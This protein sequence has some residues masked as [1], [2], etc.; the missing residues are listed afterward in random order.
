MAQTDYLRAGRVLKPQGLRGEVKVEILG[1]EPEQILTQKSFYLE[2]ARSGRP[3]AASRRQT[4]GGTEYVP[5]TVLAAALRE[6]YAYLE[7]AG[8][9]SREEAEALRGAYLCIRREDALPLPEG[10]WYIVDL[11]GCRAFGDDGRDYGTL[12]DIHQF[13]AA[14]IY[15]LRPDEGTE[16][17]WTPLAEGL[18]LDVNLQEKKLLLNGE[19]VRQCGVWNPR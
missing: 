7:L 18:L 3:Q 6:G 4:S 5:V 12:V 2:P 16:D 11:L 15:V 9:A 19:R 1:E 14:D 13:G 8:Y 17:L 10:R